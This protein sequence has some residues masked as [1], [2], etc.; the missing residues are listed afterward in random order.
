M[1][2]ARCVSQGGVTGR[3][4]VCGRGLK[5]DMRCDAAAEE[6]GVVGFNGVHVGGGCERRA[7]SG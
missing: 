5:H 3:A 2:C 7:V 1:G 6:I 4:H